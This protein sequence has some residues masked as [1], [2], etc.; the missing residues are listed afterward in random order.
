VL[1]GAVNPPA[2]EVPLAILPSEDAFELAFAV[3]ELSEEDL[4]T[5]IAS[6]VDAPDVAG[7]LA[8]IVHH[9]ADESTAAFLDFVP[10]TGQ[11]AT[12]AKV[13]GPGHRGGNH[14][15]AGVVDE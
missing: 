15:I 3:D 13:D 6:A 8:F 4:L 1:A 7:R 14:S 10:T 2:A 11:E 5:V 9:A 12:L